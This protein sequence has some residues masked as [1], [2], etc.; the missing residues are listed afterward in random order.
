MKIERKYNLGQSVWLIFDNKI[1][2][3][4]IKEII[5][6]VTVAGSEIKYMARA[7]MNDPLQL[8]HESEL[9]ASKADLLNS[10]LG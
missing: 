8:C 4:L 1:R 2:E 9:F 10:L 7:N 6:Y 5:I 3:C